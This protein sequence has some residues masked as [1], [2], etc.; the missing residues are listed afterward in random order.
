MGST[1]HREAWMDALLSICGGSAVLRDTKKVG[2]STTSNFAGRSIRCKM[3]EEEKDVWGKLPLDVQEQL[4]AFLPA[5]KLFELQVVC[6]AWRQLICCSPSFE[7]RWQSIR[8]SC[9]PNIDLLHV[10]MMKSH[11]GSLVV[12]IPM[13]RQS[14]PFSSFVTALPPMSYAKTTFGLFRTQHLRLLGGTG[15][16]MFFERV[17]ARGQ[18][19][20]VYDTVTGQVKDL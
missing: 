5:P 6:R 7:E 12:Y 14:A 16:F 17:D 3:E 9:E 11:E 4:L 10:W 2:W 19:L 15:K 13:L 8:T 18:R 1:R 20:T